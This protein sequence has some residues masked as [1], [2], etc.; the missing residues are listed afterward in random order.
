MLDFGGKHNRHELILCRLSTWIPLMVDSSSSNDFYVSIPT[1]SI[2]NSFA[3]A[4]Q[5]ACDMTFSNFSK[6]CL[7]G[8]C[9]SIKILE[10]TCKEGLEHY[11]NNLHERLISS[12]GNVPLKAL[13]LRYKLVKL[14][15]SI[16]NWDLTPLEHGYFLF[17]LTSRE[18]I[19][20]KWSAGI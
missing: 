13:E 14:R 1:P 7:K 2:K 18:N 16:T 17:S 11:N 4:L 5:N 8:N 3:C 12:K 10:E 19:L 6:S 15:S 9:L 20:E